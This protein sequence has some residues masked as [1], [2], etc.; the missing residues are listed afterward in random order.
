[1]LRLIISATIIRSYIKL[2]LTIP[3]SS[4]KNSQTQPLVPKKKLKKIFKVEFKIF[5]KKILTKGLVWEKN[6]GMVG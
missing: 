1:M 5:E 4:K 3:K 6:I 2:L